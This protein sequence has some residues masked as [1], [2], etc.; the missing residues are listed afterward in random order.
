MGWGAR[1]SGG[2]LDLVDRWDGRVGEIS[3]IGLGSV[4]G[5]SVKPCEFLGFSF[6]PVAHGVSSEFDVGWIELLVIVFFLFYHSRSDSIFA[7]TKM[8]R[9]NSNWTDVRCNRIFF[10]R[11][12]DFMFLD[13]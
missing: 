12:M 2:R 1:G 4:A 10:H 9:L 8:G 11:H 6:F 7:A 5:A 13:D 3:V